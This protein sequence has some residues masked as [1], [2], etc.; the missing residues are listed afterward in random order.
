MT[1]GLSIGDKNFDVLI[2]DTTLRDGSQGEGLSFS[3]EDKI[4][5]AKK[6]DY[7]G[8]SYIEGGWPGSNPK[9]LEFFNVARN[10]EWQH[11][12]IAAFSSTRKPD[13]SVEQDSNI[14]ALLQ[15]G[16]SVATIFGKSW[17]FH[18]MRALETTLEENLAMI[19]DTIDFLK[20]KGMDVIFDAEH[21]FDGYKNNPDYALQVLACAANAGAQCL[22]LCDTNGGTMPWE[23]EAIIKKV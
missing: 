21:F 23:L 18:V 14:K 4:K 19:R 1:G 8:I 16:V 15:T 11:A 2:Y 22:V 9:D 6:L 5:I 7:L 12:R 10:M 20:N 3:L 17:D 13:V